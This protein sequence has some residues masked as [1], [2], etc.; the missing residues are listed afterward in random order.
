[1]QK[2]QM[3]LFTITNRGTICSQCCGYATLE[4]DYSVYQQPISPHILASNGAIYPMQN[5]VWWFSVSQ[6]PQRIS[7]HA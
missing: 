6:T 2:P 3:F 7:F 5:L 1:M 4:L